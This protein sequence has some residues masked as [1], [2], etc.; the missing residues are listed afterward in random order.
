MTSHPMFQYDEALLRSCARSSVAKFLMDDS[1]CCHVE[2]IRKDVDTDDDDDDVVGP[3]CTTTRVSITNRWLLDDSNNNDN[4]DCVSLLKLHT[5]HYGRHYTTAEIYI[6]KYECY[7]STET[8]TTGPNISTSCCEFVRENTIVSYEVGRNI[9]NFIRNVVWM[10]RY[11]SWIWD[12]H[13][14]HH[15]HHH[16][17][18]ALNRFSSDDILPETTRNRVVERHDNHEK[19]RRRIAADPSKDSTSSSSS[20][21]IDDH[22]WMARD[23]D[24]SSTSL[25]S[26]IILVSTWD[27]ILKHHGIEKYNVLHRIGST[28]HWNRYKWRPKKKKRHRAADARNQVTFDLYPTKLRIPTHEQMV[29]SYRP[30]QTPIIPNNNNNEMDGS[31]VLIG[32]DHH[33]WQNHHHHHHDDDPM[34][35]NDPFS[36]NINW[37]T[38]NN[39]DGVS[40]VHD[41]IDQVREGKKCF[42]F[43]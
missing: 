1:D 31:L 41:P 28:K 10:E 23:Q 4:E 9:E 20:S 27:D 14:L 18:V 6:R 12:D 38:M 33:H 21:R 30:F 39:P 43:F 11:N 19:S 42:D 25:E 34:D 8:T 7:L 40:I 13:M 36:Q 35:K 15:H 24:D 16:H 17:R 22:E 2:K 3:N 29:H 32:R 26:D 37:A 5:Q